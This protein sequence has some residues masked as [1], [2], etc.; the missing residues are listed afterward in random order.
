MIALAETGG[1]APRTLTEFEPLC[2]G[3]NDDCARLE[4]LLA[5]LEADLAQVKRRHLRALKRQAAA[6]A[7]REAALHEALAGAPEL[8]VRP[9]TAVLHGTKIGY[10]TGVGS[11]VF[12]DEAR[13]VQLIEK[14]LP[15]RFAELVKTEHTPRKDALRTLSASELSRLGC[16]V[17]G[18]GD[19]IVLKRA[20]GDV[21]KLISRLIDKLVTGM[22]GEK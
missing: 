12:A 19:M 3:Y 4:D 1:A 7:A 9:R 10:A 15:G 5:A 20:A 6:V 14:H 16:R 17:E 22:V 2:A 11:V 8:F 18:G 13:V 21:E